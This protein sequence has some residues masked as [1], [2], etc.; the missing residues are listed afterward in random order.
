MG[1]I[2]TPFTDLGYTLEDKFIVKNN[3]CDLS[4][5]VNEGDVV[6][7]DYDD[8][9]NCPRFISEKGWQGNQFYPHIINVN[10][11]EKLQG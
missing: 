8:G 1:C 11:L 4:A 3:T 5:T 9:S 2:K 7:L 6:W 10:D